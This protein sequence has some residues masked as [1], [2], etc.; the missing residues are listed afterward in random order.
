[1]QYIEQ[2]L[3]RVPPHVARRHSKQL[4]SVVFMPQ[5]GFVISISGGQ[6][7]EELLDLLP[8]YSLAFMGDEGPAGVAGAA[9]AAAWGSSEVELDRS[10]AYYTC[11][12]TQE[13]NAEFGNLQHKISD[14]EVRWGLRDTTR[15]T[16]V[17]RQLQPW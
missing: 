17:A 11:S 4:W 2:E 1:M 10:C 5:V 14:L 7:A 15:L 3:S 9:A 6:L 13:L 12:C 16:W 8:D